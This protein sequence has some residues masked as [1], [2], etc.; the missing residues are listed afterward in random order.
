MFGRRFRTATSMPTR[1]IVIS[2]AE[3]LFASMQMKG[4]F[5]CLPVLNALQRSRQLVP[6]S[7]ISERKTAIWVVDTS[8]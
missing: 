1:R 8:T 5:V 7:L 2:E 4:I 6:I 3:S